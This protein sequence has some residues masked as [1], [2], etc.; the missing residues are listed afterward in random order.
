MISK[1][2]DPMTLTP[3]QLARVR[4][5]YNHE[6]DIVCAD[7]EIAGREVDES[8]AHRAGIQRV[9]DDLGAPYDVA[10]ATVSRYGV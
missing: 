1:Y 7:A 5:L 8:E 9:A 4:M 2:P 6:Q 3:E 10:D